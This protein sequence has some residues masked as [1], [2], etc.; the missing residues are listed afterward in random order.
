VKVIF[1]RKGFD[2]QYGKIPN[3]VLPDQT[4]VS[5]PIEDPKSVVKADEVRRG[6]EPIGVIVEQLTGR[7][8]QRS[9]PAHLDPDLDASAYPRMPGWRPVLGQTGSSLGHLGKQGVGVG[10][11]FLFFG[12]YRQLERH[13]STWSFAPG[14]PAMHTLWGWL[15]VGACHLHTD[16]PQNA[17]KWLAYHPHLQRSARRRHLLYVGSDHLEVAGRAVAGGGYFPRFAAWRVLSAPGE[18]MSRWR[19][20]GWMHPEAGQVRFSYIHDPT[21]WSRTDAGSAIVQT[22]GKGQE[23]VM[24][25][26]KTAPLDQWLA[27][28]FEDVPSVAV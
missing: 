8:I 10:D 6:G 24:T 22:V 18:N 5:F 23:I 15:H 1:S 28:L 13:G 2:S 4:L 25:A 26:E 19:L 9:Y 12:W 21:R 7:R 27:M 16:V 20:P 11:L 3:A 17:A 14:S